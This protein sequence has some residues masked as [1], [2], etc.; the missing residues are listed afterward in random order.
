M[1]TSSLS[2]L[3]KLEKVLDQKTEVMVERMRRVTTAYEE[4]EPEAIMQIFRQSKFLLQSPI[5]AAEVFFG[6]AG[7]RVGVC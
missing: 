3:L 2:L 7:S 6:M 4:D 1:N 5:G